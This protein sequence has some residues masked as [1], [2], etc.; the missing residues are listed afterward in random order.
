MINCDTGLAKKFILFFF[1]VKYYRKTRTNFFAK[2]CS[3]IWILHSNEK[4]PYAMKWILETHF[5]IDKVIKIT[6]IIWQYFYKAQTQSKLNNV[7]LRDAWMCD[8]MSL[9]NTKNAINTNIKKLV[10]FQWGWGDIGGR[11]S[12]ESPKPFVR[13][14]P[15]P[16]L[17][18]HQ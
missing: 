13:A 3:H 17:Q 16:R 2:P 4:E 14:P 1:S 15:P 8:E 9:T 18:P 12:G 10:I 5:W 6:Y 7:L 11:G